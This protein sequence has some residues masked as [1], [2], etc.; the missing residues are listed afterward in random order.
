MSILLLISSLPSTMI[1]FTFTLAEKESS[2]VT[3]AGY[4]N[5]NSIHKYY[6]ASVL[7]HWIS[8]YCKNV[9]KLER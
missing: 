5:P 3:T 2:L 6:Q 9:D 7:I 1:V 8:I 4:Y